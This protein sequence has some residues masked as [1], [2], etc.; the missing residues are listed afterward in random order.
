[1]MKLLDPNG[2]EPLVDGLPCG[3]Q[4]VASA[5]GQC[6][7]AIHQ[8]PRICTISAPWATLATGLARWHMRMRFPISMARDDLHLAWSK[9]RRGIRA[10]RH[11][12]STIQWTV[13]AVHGNLFVAAASGT[14]PQP[15]D[16]P[17]LS[18]ISQADGRTLDSVVGLPAFSSEIYSVPQ[19]DRINDWERVYLV[20][21]FGVLAVIPTSDDR[22]HLRPFDPIAR[23]QS[24]Q[25]AYLL[26]DSMPPP[27][28]PAWQ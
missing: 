10:T 5:D 28:A 23:L 7:S 20:P 6:L 17:T 2:L 21:E 16:L 3:E 13:P 26:I 22:V 18:I 8:G 27:A 1:M 24:Q 19:A 4:V 12:V 15:P 14:L 25:V 9:E 11:S